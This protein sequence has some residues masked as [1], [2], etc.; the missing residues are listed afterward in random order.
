MIDRIPSAIPAVIILVPERHR[1]GRGWFAEVFRGEWFP[2]IEFVQDNVSFSSAAR[3]IRGLHFQ[4]EPAAQAKLVHVARGAIRDVA[5]DLRA[6]S[7]TYLHHV[8]IEVDASDGRHILI[9]SGFAHGYVTL[10]PDTVVAYKVSAYY[11]PNLERGIRWDDP[12][13]GIDWGLDRPPILSDR[14]RAH[15][16]FDASAPP[17]DTGATP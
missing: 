15:P 3:T 2:E 5:V 8:T 14:D 4:V 12:A 7:P 16:P 9:P 17:F 10:E 6:G 13:L 11:R 1:D